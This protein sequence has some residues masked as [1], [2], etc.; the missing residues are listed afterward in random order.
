MSM[1]VVTISKV[2]PGRVMTTVFSLSDGGTI[3]RVGDSVGVVTKEVVIM[4]VVTTV[5][6]S[7][8]SIF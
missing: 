6:Q 5:F 8:V 2:T 3:P 7:K 1:I 4:V